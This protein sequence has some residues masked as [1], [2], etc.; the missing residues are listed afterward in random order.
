MKKVRLTTNED[1][2]V[3]MKKIEPYVPG[4]WDKIFW[5]L[6]SNRKRLQTVEMEVYEAMLSIVTLHNQLV[7]A[8][9]AINALYAQLIKDKN[10]DGGTGYA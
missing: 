9:Q 6:P 7:K 3:N 1:G 4:K 8:I 2:L 5:F 10:Q